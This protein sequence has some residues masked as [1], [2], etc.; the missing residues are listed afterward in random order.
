MDCEEVKKIIPN[1]FQHTASE[2]EIR[3]VEEH[4]CVCHD[5]RTALGELMDN[6]VD[7]ETPQPEIAAET[8]QPP[9]LEPEPQ[10]E[11]A[12]YYPSSD[13]EGP[14]KE[15][16]PSPAQEIKKDQTAGLEKP[17]DEL[18]K[19]ADSEEKTPLPNEENLPVGSELAKEATFPLDQQ[20]IGQR[21][22]GLFEYA[23]LALGLL[24]L[25]F[26][27]YLAFKG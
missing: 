9:E 20:P 18:L 7:R 11:E 27:I 23:A 17:E 21:K 5:C 3:K 24:V 25:G 26:F 10:K 13:A 16:Q 8:K 19:P 14:V 6:L 2:E 22:G 12:V 1:Y 15:I 4:L